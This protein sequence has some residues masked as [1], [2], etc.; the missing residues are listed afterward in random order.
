MLRP[1]GASWGRS[2]LLECKQQKHRPALRKVLLACS[3]G[4]G[5]G[6]TTR[7]RYPLGGPV[8]RRRL[9]E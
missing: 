5:C 9:R 8:R 4:A 1:Q 6:S 2:V 3:L 7:L